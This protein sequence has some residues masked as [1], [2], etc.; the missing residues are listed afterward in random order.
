[1]F[2]ASGPF[3]KKAWPSVHLWCSRWGYSR[4]STRNH[5]V[6]S[7]PCKQAPCAGHLK[8]PAR[9]RPFSMFQHHTWTSG[10][11][12]KKQVLFVYQH[13]TWDVRRQPDTTVLPRVS[14]VHELWG[15]RTRSHQEANRPCKS[16]PWDGHCRGSLLTHRLGDKKS[17]PSVTQLPA[18]SNW[19]INAGTH[20]LWW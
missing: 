7:P 20:R 8:E 5:Q 9:C 10:E 19:L 14:A 15:Q 3:P 1:M 12:S 11:D 6:A 4:K 17:N 13:H 2:G 18:V 16:V